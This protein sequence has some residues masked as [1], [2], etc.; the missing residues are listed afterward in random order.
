MTVSLQ[1]IVVRFRNEM[2][3]AL[4]NLDRRHS[5]SESTGG[6]NHEIHP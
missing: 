3:Q 4:L 5:D 6:M 1:T 2:A